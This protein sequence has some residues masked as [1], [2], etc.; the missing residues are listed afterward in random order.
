[1]LIESKNKEIAKYCNRYMELKSSP[2]PDFEE[3]SK[4]LNVKK[5][6]LKKLE[7]H[8][9]IN[10]VN[11]SEKLINHLKITPKVLNEKIQANKESVVTI[12][13]F[14]ETEVTIEDVYIEIRAPHKS[15]EQEVFKKSLHFKKETKES[16]KIYFEIIPKTKP[17]CPI[18]VRFNFNELIHGNNPIPFPIPLLIEVE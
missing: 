2:Y 5:R 8:I 4:L 14:K 11:E 13:F 18:E 3:L 16:K 10:H 7:K 1:M 9:L 12:E 15:L 6:Y 17:F